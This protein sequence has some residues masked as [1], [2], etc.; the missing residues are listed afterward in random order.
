MISIRAF[1]GLEGSSERHLGPSVRLP[2][3]RVDVPEDERRTDE[4]LS[5]LNLTSVERRMPWLNN[6]SLKMSR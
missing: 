6:S 2:V 3:R 5:A 1:G 4:S